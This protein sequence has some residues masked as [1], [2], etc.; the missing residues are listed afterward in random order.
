M[1]YIKY[2]VK[3][4]VIFE[5][6]QI[7]CNKSRVITKIIMAF[8][9]VLIFGSCFFND[10]E[11]CDELESFEIA[12]GLYV[13]KYRTFCGGAIG[14]DAITSYITDSLTFRQKIGYE[15][16]HD[17]LSVELKG[18]IVEAYNIEIFYSDEI[19][20][21]KTFTKEELFQFQHTAKNCINTTPIFGINS[22]KCDNYNPSH[23]GCY[24]RE[25]G[26]Y[27]TYTQFTCDTGGGYDYLN[28]V[29]FTDSL[30]FSAF[31]GIYLPGKRKNIYRVEQE[32]KEN[33]IFYN[34]TTRQEADTI[35]CAS[36]PLAE[37]RKGKL[38]EVCNPKK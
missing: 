37:L 5:K 9:S 22:L 12:D 20:E 8:F 19:I 28:A 33:F 32:G 30:N 10:F 3:L 16:D 11:C 26:Y 14:G 1:N 38:I 15:Y 13:E 29:F 23:V 2:S 18:E 36:F 31:I 27:V 25:N 35:R 4:K 34:I 21:Q 17:H 24:Q 6:V 7:V